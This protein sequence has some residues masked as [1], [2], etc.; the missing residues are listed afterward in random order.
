MALSEPGGQPEQTG[1][2]QAI[3]L[4]EPADDH[5]A[6]SS[7]PAVN[8]STPPPDPDMFAHT[9]SISPSSLPWRRQAPQPPQPPMRPTTVAPEKRDRKR[10]P[11][12]LRRRCGSGAVGDQRCLHRHV[13]ARHDGGGGAPRRVNRPPKR[14]PEWRADRGC[15]RRPRRGGGHRGRRHHLGLRRHGGRQPRQRTTRGLRPRASTAGRAAKTYPFRC[16]TRWR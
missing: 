9:A 7:V 2:T 16:S 6:R 13:I 1:G 12:R 3:P 15:A 10:D 4:S 11:D 14:S 5:P 8:G